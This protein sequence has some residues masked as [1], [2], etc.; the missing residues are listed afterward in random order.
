MKKHDYRRE[1]AVLVKLL[2]RE[3]ERSG[4]TQRQLAK[5]LGQSQSY[6]SKI[7]QGE[8][9]LDVIQLRRLCHL[10]GTTLAEMVAALEQEP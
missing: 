4:L 1:Y 2:R 7:E 10:M 5:K 3:R 8:L 9:R 6:V